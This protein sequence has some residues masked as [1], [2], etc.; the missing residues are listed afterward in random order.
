MNLKREDLIGTWKSS[1]GSIIELKKDG[2]YIAKAINYNIFYPNKELE[3]KTFDFTGNWKIINN[4]EQDNKLELNSNA[5]FSDYGI[6][7]TYTIDG[8]VRS[9]KIGLS[10]EISGEGI[11]ENKPPYYLFNWLGDPD[12]MNK[13][14]FIKE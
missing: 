11:F 10:F 13:Y 2:S 8:K 12:D 7:D 6:N 4:S 1:D 5:T 9:H 3:K 14:K